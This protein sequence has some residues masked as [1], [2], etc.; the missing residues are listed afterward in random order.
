MLQMAK[1][2]KRMWKDEG[3]QTDFNDQ[4]ESHKYEVGHSE[5]RTLAMDCNR[6]ELRRQEKYE[7]LRPP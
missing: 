6:E 2:K 5:K 3:R 7:T 4:K 1:V